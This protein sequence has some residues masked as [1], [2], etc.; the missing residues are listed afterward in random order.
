MLHA[1]I[2]AHPLGLLISAGKD[3]PVA[4]PLPFLLDADIAPHGRLR[5]HLA[6]ANPQ[7]R[8]L[9]DDPETPVLVVFQGVDSLCD[10]V[11]VR[12]QARDRQGRADLELRDRPGSRPVARH[13]RPWMAG[14]QIAELTAT[15]EGRAQ[16]ALGGERCAATPTSQSQLKGIVGMEIEITEISGKWKVSQNRPE[17]DRGG[18]AE[19]L[20]EAADDHDAAAMAELVQALWWTGRLRS[21]LWRSPAS[22]ISPSSA[23]RVRRMGAKAAATRHTGSCRHDTPASTPPVTACRHPVVVGKV[24]GRPFIER[25]A[26]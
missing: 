20:D 25:T 14:R 17:G 3:G 10:A 16:R 12:D 7:W 4:N 24:S 11:L 13:R 8:L 22:E 26:R 15:H 18:V 5:A 9:A 23:A 1:L 21:R 6:K 2:R 19:G